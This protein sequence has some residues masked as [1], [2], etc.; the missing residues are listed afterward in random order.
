[1]RTALVFACLVGMACAFSVSS[2]QWGDPPASLGLVWGACQLSLS[3]RSR[4]GCGE[5]SRMTRT[6]TR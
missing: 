2:G 5:P 4:T 6:K 1:M 3:P